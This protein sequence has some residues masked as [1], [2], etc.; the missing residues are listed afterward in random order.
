ME[1]TTLLIQKGVQLKARDSEGL[2][3]IYQVPSLSLEK[4]RL[5]VIWLALFRLH[6]LV[7]MQ[8]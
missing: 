1:V 7:M 8:L 3:P 4:L 6:S 5:V 2:T